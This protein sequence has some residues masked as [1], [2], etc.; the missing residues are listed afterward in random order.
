MFKMKNLLVAV[1]LLA[2]AITASIAPISADSKIKLSLDG[3]DL[4]VKVSPVSSGGKMYVPIKEAA[5]AIGGIVTWSKISKRMTITT[6]DKNIVINGNSNKAVVNHN[7]IILDGTTKVI[8]G[9]L[10]VPFSFLEKGLGI[11]ATYSASSKS[12]TAK[13]FTNMKGTLKAGG[14]TTIEPIASKA[15]IKLMEMNKGL[16]VTVAKGGSGE[17]IKGAYNGTFNIGNAS[18][19]LTD[20]DKKTY[21]GLVSTTIGR[22]GIAIIV[23]KKNS[24]KNLSTQQVFDIFTGKISNWAD[25]GGKKAP[26]NVYTRESG[27]GTLTS[28]VE[29]ALHM[30]DKKASVVARATPMAENGT[31]LNA[32]SQDENSIGFLSLGFVESRVKALDIE[33]VTPNSVNC[34]SGN[35]KYV[36]PLNVLTKGAPSGLAAKFINYLLSPDG[37][38]MIVKEG[39]L[40]LILED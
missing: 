10:L 39:Y 29:L 36:R 37:Q 6:C 20:T 8:D 21:P 16:S 38:L 32:I 28:F 30:Y 18:R 40:P 2:V 15:A 19:A 23:N 35:Y 26:I 31:V 5:E 34:L 14:S 24:V 22:D 27:S 12:I 11:Y 4:A 33:N 7:T 9:T 13:Y 3:K 25:V 1:I 17:G